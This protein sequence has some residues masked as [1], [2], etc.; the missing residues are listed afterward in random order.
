ML[1]ISV[2]VMNRLKITESA[3]FIY[4]MHSLLPKDLFRTDLKVLQLLV[5]EYSSCL[6]VLYHCD[7]VNT[8]LVWVIRII[9][10]LFFKVR[11]F[12]ICFGQ[13]MDFL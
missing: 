11:V 2:L 9:M 8:R 4:L 7:R 6:H 10:T 1:H 12:K 3:I 5:A 13:R